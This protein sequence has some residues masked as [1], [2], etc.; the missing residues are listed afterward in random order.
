[1]ENNIRKLIHEIKDDLK[2]FNL[3]DNNEMEQIIPYFEIINCQACTALF[4]EGEP[5][6]FVGFIASGR[7]EIK[8]QTEFKGRQIILAV[9]SKGS[10]VGELSMIDYQPRS[11]TASAV[12]DS[13]L[14]ILRREAFNSLTQKHPYIGI[15]ILKGLNQILATR[16]RKAVD[17]LSV[18]F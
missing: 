13:T 18:I 8:K 10:L 2:I 7:L 6:D 3:L 1:M 16:L 14:I 9:L 11:A 5:G 17:R 12:E 15:K 4:N